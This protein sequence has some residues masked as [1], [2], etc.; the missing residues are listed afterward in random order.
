[1]QPAHAALHAEIIM[2]PPPS[3]PKLRFPTLGPGQESPP[4][5]NSRARPCS[6]RICSSYFCIE[7]GSR[8]PSV[9]HRYYA[10]GREVQQTLHFVYSCTVSQMCRLHTVK[11]P[12]LC[13]TRDLSLPE[14]SLCLLW[15]QQV[16]KCSPEGA[17]EK[18][19]ASRD[20]RPY[21]IPLRDHDHS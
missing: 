11:E 14:T 10:L 5:Q 6:Q 21:K 8:R 17:P 19:R 12:V 9:I 3:G 4:L 13:A 1:M 7:P 16:T 20:L 2:L 15:R 18:N